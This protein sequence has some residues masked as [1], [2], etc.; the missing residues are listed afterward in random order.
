MQKNLKKNKDFELREFDKKVEENLGKIY[1]SQNGKKSDFTALEKKSKNWLKM[2]IIGQFIMLVSLFLFLGVM[3]Y[4]GSG[5]SQE[6]SG[7]D[8]SFEL[9]K[10]ISSGDEGEFIIKYK[11]LEDFTLYNVDIGVNF[12]KGFEFGG[13]DPLP[14]NQY[15]TLWKV[16]DILRGEEGAIRVRGK[17]IGEV[18]SLITMKASASYRPENFSSDFKKAFVAPTLQITKSIL[19]VTLNAP[20]QI[21]TNQKT[22]FSIR[23]KNTTENPFSNIKIQ[24][25]YPAGFAFTGSRPAPEENISK[26]GGE[27]EN[28]EAKINNIWKVQELQAGEEGEIAV[29]GEFRNLDTNMAQLIVESGMEKDDQFVVYQRNEAEIE[30]ISPGFKVD[31]VVNGS[32]EDISVNFSDTLNYSIIYK[33]LGAKTL[34]DVSMVSYLDSEVVDWE[35]LIDKNDGIR[36]GNSLY[37][38]SA[39]VPEFALLNPLDEGEINFS[40]K[41][42]DLPRVNL[43]NAKLETTMRAEANIKKIEELEVNIPVISKSLVSDINTDLELRVQGR[44]FDDDNIAVGQG[45]LP[46]QIGKKTTFRIYWNLSN[47]LHDVSDVKGK[48]LLS[49]EVVWEDKFLVSQ[50]ELLYDSKDHSVTWTIPKIPPKK[51]FEELE[52][53]FDLSVVPS[54]EM[55][56]KLILLTSETS[57]TALDQVTH[58]GISHLSLGIS[59]NLEDDPFGGGR[60]LVVSGENS[61]E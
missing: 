32:K 10:E 21:V 15:N 3:A 1:E 7:I 24:A 33:N 47:N 46:P 60:G 44:Y 16:G 59:S 50:G 52:A 40:V 4:L 19:Q 8:V 5:K 22:S 12:P 26:K 55:A 20:K 49:R 42:K 23:Y 11:N 48:T 45:P 27:V 41:I 35:T 9:P 36:Q 58:S 17:I 38:N 54:A 31:V 30:I 39:S 53:W 43:E 57:L 61:N 37:W 18:G 56:G 29:E 14:S 13:S 28:A 25:Y 34:Y 6:E 2:I 51:S